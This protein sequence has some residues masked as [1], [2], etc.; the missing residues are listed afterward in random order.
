MEG[1]AQ[2][3]SRG[4]RMHMHRAALRQEESDREKDVERERKKR[5]KKMA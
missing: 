5:R 1:K 3:E 2:P 4:E